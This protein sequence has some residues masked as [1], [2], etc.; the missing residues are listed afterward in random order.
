[1]THQEKSLTP[2]LGPPDP[3]VPRPTYDEATGRWSDDDP[4]TDA[5]KHAFCRRR[6]GSPATIAP[7]QLYDRMAMLGCDMRWYVRESE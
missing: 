1:M 4:K 2:W 5:E 3:G 6:T 7:P